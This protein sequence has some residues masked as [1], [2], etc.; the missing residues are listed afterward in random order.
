MK[1]CRI[2][3][4]ARA[5]TNQKPEPRHP[6]PDELFGTVE[7]RRRRR[8]VLWGTVWAACVLIW[9]AVCVQAVIWWIGG[10]R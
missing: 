7:R 8:V 10:P 5:L 2:T 6:D 4:T 9:A 1:D 3:T